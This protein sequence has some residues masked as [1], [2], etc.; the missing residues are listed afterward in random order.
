MRQD[1]YGAHVAV[2]SRF[3]NQI[4]DLL[5]YDEGGLNSPDRGGHACAPWGQG[6]EAPWKNR[7]KTYKKHF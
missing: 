3:P 5:R 2:N 4:P 1:S 7:R 6:K